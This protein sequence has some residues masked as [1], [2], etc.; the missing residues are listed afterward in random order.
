[1]VTPRSLDSVYN[2]LTGEF[3]AFPSRDRKGATDI[4]RTA[5]RRP[6]PYGRGSEIF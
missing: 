5:S 4:I 6:L 3:D 2:P 1:M